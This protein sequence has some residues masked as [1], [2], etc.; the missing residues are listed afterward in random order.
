MYEYNAYKLLK[1]ANPLTNQILD[2]NRVPWRQLDGSLAGWLAGRLDVCL[3]G[4]LLHVVVNE[5][6]DE[7]ILVRF[8]EPVKERQCYFCCRLYKCTDNVG[9]KN[10]LKFLLCVLATKTLCYVYYIHTSLRSVS[11][12]LSPHIYRLEQIKESSKVA[13]HTLDR[14]SSEIR[15]M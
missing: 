7:N 1:N 3:L 2:K 10:G 8:S 14:S 12:L 11:V 5:P 6:S 4:F 9:Q 15:R 13:A